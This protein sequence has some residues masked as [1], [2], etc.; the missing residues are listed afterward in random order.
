[1]ITMSQMVTTRQIIRQ[2]WQMWSSK[3]IKKLEGIMIKDMT[4]IE[5][6]LD[7]Q[8]T[9]THSPDQKCSLKWNENGKK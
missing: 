8:P 3:Y 9:P 7:I 2:D 5:V 1:M 4:V 6:Q